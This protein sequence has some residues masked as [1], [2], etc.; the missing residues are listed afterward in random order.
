MTIYNPYS[1]KIRPEKQIAEVMLMTRSN[2]KKLIEQERITISDRPIFEHTAI[3]QCRVGIKCNDF[4]PGFSTVQHDGDKLTDFK[5]FRKEMRK[6][7]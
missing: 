7:S 6:I 4:F 3:H 1:I 5:M 2:V